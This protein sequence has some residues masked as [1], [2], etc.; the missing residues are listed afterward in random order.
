MKRATTRRYLIITILFLTTNFLQAQKSS[1]L[2]T[3][4]MDQPATHRFHLAMTCAGVKGDSIDLK[5]PVWSPGY[6]QRLDFADN[7]E[8]FRVANASGRT[9]GWRKLAGS[10]WRIDNSSASEILEY[11]VKTIRPFVGTPYL[12][13]ERG[14]ILP[15]GIFLYPAGKIQHPVTVVIKPFVKWTNVATGL[16]SVAGKPNTY[17]APDYDILYDSP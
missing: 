15:A 10:T 12:D 7:V 6:Y 3:V 1:I 9:A 17:T 16:D 13:E 5:M 8:N 11:D 14:Y 2:F 4:S